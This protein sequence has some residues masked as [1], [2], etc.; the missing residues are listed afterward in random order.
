MNG[1]PQTRDLVLVGGG[2]AHALVLRMWGMNPLPGARLTVIDPSPMVAYSGML[3]GL[4]AGHYGLDVLSI[5]LVRLARFAGARLIT[6]PVTGLDPAGRVI[7]V[8]GRP[9]VAYDLASIDIGVTSAMP[10]IPGFADHAVPVKPLTPFAAAWT[11]LMAQGAAPRI[12]VIG[13]GVAGA[14]IAMAMAHRLAGRGSVDLVERGRALAVLGGGARARVL[15]ALR[16]LGVSLHEQSPVA[17]VTAQGVHLTDGRTIPASFVCGAAGAHPQGWLEGSGLALHEGFVAVDRHLQSS[18]PAVFAAGDCAHMTATPRPKAGVFAVRQAPVLFANLRATLAGGALRPYAPQRDYL[19]LVSLGGRRALAEKWGLA[20]AAPAL[21]RW[22]DRID[23]RFMARLDDLPVMPAPAVPVPAARGLS[24]IL[25]GAPLCGGCGAKVDRAILGTALAGLP[26]A[27]GDV[28]RLPGD[29]AA[30]I[31][32]GGAR[33]VITTDHLRAVTDEPV[34]MT[35][36]AAIHALGDIWA[37]GATPQAALVTLIL[38]RLSPDLQARTMAEIME[39]ATLVM[40]EAGAAIAGGH[41]SQGEE[42]TIGFTLTGL[43]EGDPVTLA[44]GRAGDALILTKAVGAGVIL[45]AAM[46]GQARGPDVAACHAAMIRPQGDAARVL[47]GARAMTDV[48]GFGLAGHLAGICAAS[49]V[50]AEVRLADVPLLPGAEALA[51]AGV[52]SS[53]W[54]G[55]RGAAGP[56]TGA[57]GPRAD[58]M[59]D[60]QTCGGLLAAVAPEEADGI[61]ARLLAQGHA[62]A[63]IGTLLD[64]P[65]AVRLR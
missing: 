15:A 42:M 48:T 21:W 35:R 64:G 54:A 2:H 23:R 13:G 11:A 24:E 43:L 40:A 45:A 41:T 57:V 59:F 26:A 55:N 16:A 32:L 3:P 50:A 38:P 14:E 65:P 39:T 58:L 52:R 7:T 1:Y 33:Q 22:K 6:A 34:L 37:M 46:R 19:K 44:G 12:V 53:L 51:A 25:S 20:L 4:V 36:I 61:L 28:D 49:G 8:P 56:V 63:R 27:R 62:A 18:D 47:R 31:R 60:P 5:D 17:G 10:D 9:G 30:L 29:D